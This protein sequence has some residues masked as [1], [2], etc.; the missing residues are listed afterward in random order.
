MTAAADKLRAMKSP[1]RTLNK[2]AIRDIKAQKW[3]FMAATFLVFLGVSL[4]VG[5][6]ASYQNIESTYNRFYSQTMLED[7]G[8]YFSPSPPSILKKIRSLSGVMDAVGRSVAYGRAFVNGKWVEV[9]LVSIPDRQSRVDKVYICS[10]SYPGKGEALI[11]AK[12]AELNSIPVGVT[13]NVKVHSKTIRLRISGT[14]Y[15]PEYVLITGETS[16]FV[17]AKDFCILFVPESTMKKLGFT[18]ISEVHIKLFNPSYAD[19][20]VEELKQI[21]GEKA[22]FIYK[23]SEQPSF[24]LLRSDLKGFQSMAFMFPSMLLA[25]S[26]T[27]VYVIMSRMVVEQSGAIAVL[28]ALGYSRRDVILHYLIHSTI[29]GLAGSVTGVFAGYLI[30]AEMTKSYIDVLNLPY[31]VV[32]FHPVTTALGFLA[33]FLSP[34]LAGFFTAKN[35]ASVDPATAMRGTKEKPAFRRFLSKLKF[36]RIIISI[37]VKNLFRNP[38][39]TAYAVMGVVAAVVL[40]TTSLAFVNSTDEMFHV[41]FGKIQKFDY[42]VQCPESYLKNIRNLKD[43]REAYPVVQ[44]WIRIE[45]DGKSR[46]LTLIALPPQNLYN[47]YT[48]SGKR[49]F[50]PPDGVYL[51]EKDAE[52]LSICSGMIVN[53][54][55]PEGKVRVRIADVFSQPLVPACYMSLSQA[56]KF[57]IRPNWIIVKGGNKNEL[58]RFGRVLSMKELKRNTQEMMGMMYAFFFFSLAFGSALSF[59]ELFNLTSISVV[60]RRREFATLRMLGYRVKEIEKIIYIELAAVCIA[61]LLIGFP[62]A[63]LTV[64]IFQSLYN[65]DVFNM[66]FVIYPW[67]YAVTV[68][69]VILTLILATRPAIAYIR[70]LDIARVS[71][72]IE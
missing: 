17:S 58:E 12:F 4:F 48:L 15:S 14:A 16:S 41:Q 66:I 59:A 20:V 45:N 69:S 55:T 31:S 43:V 11:F 25:I 62:L 47:I 49:K 50:P 60:E 68:A 71:R 23:Q 26:A 40:I 38:K 6:Y 70:K 56:E 24:K 54:Y 52:N 63:I 21:L 32:S 53:A 42:M 61:G 46:T 22:K 67:S 39:R 34:V 28:R 57:G 30:S 2:K 5:L 8:A 7:V 44:S 13:M 72:E 29:V 3:Q 18:K 33:G 10:G 27:I 9:K 36:S 65:S 64:K 37:A 35:A 1:K 19:R 51:P